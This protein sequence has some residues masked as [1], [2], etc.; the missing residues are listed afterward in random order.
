[1]AFQAV[2]WS[3]FD[4]NTDTLHFAFLR[5][6]E[7]GMYVLLTMASISFRLCFKN[8]TRK[9]KDCISQATHYLFKRWWL[10]TPHV[11][12][13]CFN[14]SL[15]TFEHTHISST[16]EEEEEEEEEKRGLEQRS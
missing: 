12:L 4:G 7:T 6:S 3:R 9:V 13:H 16:K 1:M 2:V 15:L 11:Q 5:V 14:T 10:S 8:F